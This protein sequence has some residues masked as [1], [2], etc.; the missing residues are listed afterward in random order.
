M[1]SSSECHWD[2]CPFN[3]TYVVSECK[4]FSKTV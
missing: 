3:I 4:L 1:I 2:E